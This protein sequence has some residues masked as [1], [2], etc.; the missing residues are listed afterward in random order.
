[1]LFRSSVHSAPSP[2][3]T[4]HVPAPDSELSDR[5]RQT[6]TLTAPQSTADRADE[7]EA[8]EDD[9]QCDD[10]PEG[11]DLD[12]FF[13]VPTHGRGNRESASVFSDDKWIL[14]EG[15]KYLKASVIAIFLTA[16]RSRKVTMRVLRARGVTIEDLRGTTH[17]R[18]N[19]IDL[20][21]DDLVKEIGRAHV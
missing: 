11:V 19:S 15:R 13:A 3:R 21:G 1:M 10:E 12:E 17:D 7:P 16:K 9:G 4:S 2:I 18:F 8:D 14:I 20:G 5:A 6:V